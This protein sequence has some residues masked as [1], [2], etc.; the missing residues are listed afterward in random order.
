MIYGRSNNA[1]GSES[2]GSDHNEGKKVGNACEFN[3][4]FTYKEVNGNVVDHDWVSLPPIQINDSPLFMSS[5]GKDIPETRVKIVEDGEG[6]STNPKPCEIRQDTQ[7]NFQ[8]KIEDKGGPREQIPQETNAEFGTLVP[9]VTQTSELNLIPNS[10]LS[11]I[12]VLNKVEDSHDNTDRAKADAVW[13]SPSTGVNILPD[14]SSS[15]ISSGS[16][17][18]FITLFILVWRIVLLVSVGNSGIESAAYPVTHYVDIC[19][20]VVLQQC[21]ARTLDS[22]NS[23]KQMIAF[24]SIASIVKL[25]IISSLLFYVLYLNKYSYSIS[26]TSKEVFLVRKSGP[27]NAKNTEPRTFMMPYSSTSTQLG[28]EGEGTSTQS[29]HELEITRHPRE[30]KSRE[31]RCVRDHSGYLNYRCSD[32]RRFDWYTTEPP[33]TRRSDIQENEVREKFDKE[34]RYDTLLNC[35]STRTYPTLPFNSCEDQS[36]I[37][38]T[39]AALEQVLTANEFELAKVNN[40]LMN[41]Y[42]KINVRKNEVHSNDLYGTYRK[43]AAPKMKCKMNVTNIWDG[44]PVNQLTPLLPSM[45]NS[46]DIIIHKKCVIRKMNFYIHELMRSKFISVMNAVHSI[47]FVYENTNYLASSIAIQLQSANINHDKENSL[48]QSIR[49]CNKIL[50][51]DRNNNCSR[52]RCVSMRPFYI[53]DEVTILQCCALFGNTGSGK[54]VKTVQLDQKVNIVLCSGVFKKERICHCIGLETLLQRNNGATTNKPNCTNTRNNGS[55]ISLNSSD[56][57]R[58]RTRCRWY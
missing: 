25:S 29:M 48:S 5:I 42:P 16:I 35:S 58:G 27:K 37:Q 31:S 38:S 7:M 3:V 50:C 47:Y 30:V 49:H 18:M 1:N 34:N 13:F 28:T 11:S 19:F 6:F 53:F 39:N 8:V 21:I 14:S 22:Q 40:I 24:K 45:K 12:P 32:E 36:V 2:P 9:Q 57:T 33:K 17:V 23:T 56:N 10:T 55:S 41:N 20:T 46:Y 44:Y 26:A 51:R 54:S 4:D 15:Y 52:T 43:L